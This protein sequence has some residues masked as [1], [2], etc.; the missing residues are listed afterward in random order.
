M[1]YCSLSYTVSQILKAETHIS[2]KKVVGSSL[3]TPSGKELEETL[4]ACILTSSSDAAPL[5]V[6]LCL[7]IPPSP[8]PCILATALL[9]VDNPPSSPLAFLLVRL[10]TVPDTPSLSLITNVEKFP[11]SLITNVEKSPSSSSSSSSSPLSSTLLFRILS[12]RSKLDVAVERR[13]RR[14]LFTIIV[15]ETESAS[16]SPSEST[17]PPP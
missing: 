5:P 6:F 11:S 16:S 9:I 13:L 3:I 7:P 17:A 12:A 10:T 15:P 1:E 4:P 14:L 2:I 8:T